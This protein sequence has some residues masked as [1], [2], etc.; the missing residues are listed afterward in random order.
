MQPL[1][2]ERADTQRFEADCGAEV[3]GQPKRR[4]QCVTRLAG[5]DCRHFT[6]PPPPQTAARPPPPPPPTGAGSSNERSLAA[7]R[8]RRRRAAPASRHEARPNFTVP[9]R[10]AF[11]A[12]PAPNQ[13]PRPPLGWSSAFWRPEQPQGCASDGARRG[14]APGFWREPLQRSGFQAFC[15]RRRGGAA[16]ACVPHA[17]ERPQPRRMGPAGGG[18][19]GRRGG[20]SGVNGNKAKADMAAAV[21]PHARRNRCRAARA[22]TVRRALPPRGVPPRAAAAAALPIRGVKFGCVHR[23][24]CAPGSQHIQ[25]TS[26]VQPTLWLDAQAKPLPQVGTTQRCG[27]FEAPPDLITLVASCRGCGV[28]R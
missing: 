22:H 6:P 4:H 9:S 11:G 27:A 24:V 23:A 28:A 2:L 20:Q 25:L 15:V 26:T 18:R 10:Q 19:A 3:A 16:G 5:K 7:P 21:R 14:C 13:G 1:R 17:C 8:G 12:A